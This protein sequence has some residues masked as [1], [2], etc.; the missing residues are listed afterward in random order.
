M[1][2]F[3]FYYF[4]R[5][6]E[7]TQASSSTGSLLATAEVGWGWSQKPVLLFQ[8]SCM[9]GRIPIIWA[10]AA[11]LQGFPG[12]ESWIGS[13]NGES[14]SGTMVEVMLAWMK[15]SQWFFCLF[16][17]EWACLSV[18]SLLKGLQSP[19]RH[20]PQ[21]RSQGLS[22]ALPF[23]HRDLSIWAF[24]DACQEAGIGRVAGAKSGVN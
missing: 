17:E 20:Q 23:G 9:G 16:K 2:I 4:G 1:L 22:L 12:R 18:G 3:K 6:Q 11:F 8:V 21:V 10:I 14:N 24:F 7:H 19:G 13:Q 15:F 5:G